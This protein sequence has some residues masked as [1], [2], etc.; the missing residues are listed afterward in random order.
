MGGWGPAGG[1]AGIHRSNQ[2]T[3]RFPGSAA[4]FVKWKKMPSL[5]N[6][7]LMQPGGSRR[8]QNDFT[9]QKGN[10]LILPPIMGVFKWVSY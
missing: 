1:K 6:M 5:G 10:T 2:L 4:G 7:G 9:G 3:T 8:M